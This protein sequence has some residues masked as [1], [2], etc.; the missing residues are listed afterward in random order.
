M[1]HCECTSFTVNNTGMR[2]LNQVIG[3]IGPARVYRRD[4]GAHLSTSVWTV[5]VLRGVTSESHVWANRSNQKGLPAP[6]EWNL[7]LERFFPAYL[8]EERMWLHPEDCKVGIIC[9]RCRAFTE[10][11]GE[12]C[13]QEPD[14][15]YPWGYRIAH[16]WHTFVVGLGVGTTSHQSSWPRS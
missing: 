10:R 5:C 11:V 6:S 8:L 12:R 1:E 15:A 14:S 4:A 3:H 2:F 16:R 13:R 7:V 9:D